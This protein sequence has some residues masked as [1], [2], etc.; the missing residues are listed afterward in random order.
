MEKNSLIWTVTGVSE[1]H[2]STYTFGYF[3]DLSEALEA[4]AENRGNLHECL[5]DYVAVEAFKPGIGAISLD[6]F[7]YRWDMVKRKWQSCEKPL[8]ATGTVNWAF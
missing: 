3:F 1:Q 4:V 2:F 6:E 7:W 8:F 5:Y